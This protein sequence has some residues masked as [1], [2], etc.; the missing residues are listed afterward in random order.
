M[1]RRTILVVDDDLKTVEVIRLRLESDG[2]AVISAA[3]GDE[4]LRLAQSV[5]PDLIVLDLMLPV[6]DGLDVCHILRV[7][8]ESQV[9]IIMVTAR[10]AEEDRLRGLENGADDYVVKP[11]SPRE[12]SARIVAVLRRAAPDE[13]RPTRFEQGSL[14]VD[15]QRVEA[16]LSGTV[17]KL[18]P[19]EFSLL[20]TM[21]AEP[22]RAFSRTQLTHRI[23]G[24]AYDGMERTIDV[25]IA[26]MRKKLD[27]SD[28]QSFIGTVYGIGYRFAGAQERSA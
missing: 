11:F 14:S 26:N 8:T 21:I 18:T 25:H 27:P 19:T 1:A 7:E 10:V 23:F 6:L 17:L 15:L 3:G 13:Q 16:T 9:P 12:L 28:A 24:Y 2:Y 5:R 20:A 22:D 4:A